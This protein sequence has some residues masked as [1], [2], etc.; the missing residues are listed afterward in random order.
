MLDSFT[1]VR[2]HG[3]FIDLLTMTI[4]EN[5]RVRIRYLWHLSVMTLLRILLGGIN[6]PCIIYLLLVLKSYMR[7]HVPEAGVKGMD[8]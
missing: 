3:G 4:Y 6:Y 7:T 8:T 1:C 5:L 2:C